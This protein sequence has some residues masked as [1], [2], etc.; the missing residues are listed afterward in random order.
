MARETDRTSR[1]VRMIVRYT[2]VVDEE[3]VELVSPAAAH[4]LGDTTGRPPVPHPA[5]FASRPYRVR[6][7]CWQLSAPDECGHGHRFG[8]G[9]VLVGWNNRV[10]TP[11]LSWTCRHCGH[12]TWARNP[13][14]DSGKSDESRGQEWAST[15]TARQ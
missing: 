7:G 14:R 11:T 5:V 3:S 2:V 10:P 6:E 9:R 13:N 1:V 4:G 8:P 15:T 12:V